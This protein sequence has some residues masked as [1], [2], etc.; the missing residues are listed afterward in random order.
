MTVEEFLQQPNV[1]EY[2]SQD[3]LAS[4]YYCDPPEGFTMWLMNHGINP[5][6]Y[7]TDSIPDYCFRDTAHHGNI[8]HVFL[9][10]KSVGRYCF[11]NSHIKSVT[12]SPIDI[13]KGAF[14]NCTVDNMELHLAPHLYVG[15]EAFSYSTIKRGFI[16][17]EQSVVTNGQFL[18]CTLDGRLTFNSKIL[19]LQFDSLRQMTVKELE[20]KAD[21]ITAS[22]TASYKGCNIEVLVL[23]NFTCADLSVHE[24]LKILA[25][26]A[27][28][29]ICHD[30][31]YESDIKYV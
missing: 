23:P 24:D 25:R 28:Q 19:H 10:G 4:V 31:E 15:N 27:K 21:R 1:K 13:G 11:V 9:D 6:D 30:G 7:F 26:Y 8:Q 18:H 20:I 5:F 3:D 2:L 16:E 22:G 29:V 12:G 17:S 14:Q